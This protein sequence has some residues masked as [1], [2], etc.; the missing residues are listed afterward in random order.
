VAALLLHTLVY[1][2][3]Q[4]PYLAMI[5]ELAP[6]YES[7][8]LLSGCRVVFATFAPLVAAAAP[9]S[10][11]RSSTR[12]ATCLRVLFRWRAVGVLFGTLM[13][14]VYALTALARRSDRSP[15]LMATPPVLALFA[16]LTLGLGTLS[17]ILPFFLASRLQLPPSVQTGLLGLLFVVAALSVPLW[18]RL[19]SRLGKRG[20]LSAGLVLLAVRLPSLVL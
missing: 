4:V 1:T 17:S 11:P 3:V 20:A 15:P 16:T 2:S 18:T 12:G 6:D 10:W 7:R 8:T 14:S 5:P 9:P 19:S 13:S